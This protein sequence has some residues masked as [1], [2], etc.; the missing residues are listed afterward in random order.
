M[1]PLCSEDVELDLDKIQPSLQ[2]LPTTLKRPSGRPE[3]SRPPPSFGRSRRE[4]LGLSSHYSVARASPGDSGGW[5]PSF[6]CRAARGSYC[7]LRRQKDD[8]VP[9][10]GPP[11][12]PC[13]L[14]GRGE[15]RTLGQLALAP[16]P[17]YSALLVQ[18]DLVPPHLLRRPV[19]QGE[20]Q[21][22]PEGATSE[23]FQVPGHTRRAPWP[24]PPGGHCSPPNS[25][26]HLRRW[27]KG[28]G[29]SL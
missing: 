1:R 20:S 7:G 24:W 12:L 4:A 2:L 29:R 22:W 11:A 9:N 5:G 14:V 10:P 23:S 16:H 15:G 26:G 13:L 28:P 3:A 17:G 25:C 21:P 27:V 19:S 18:E 8:G 6:S